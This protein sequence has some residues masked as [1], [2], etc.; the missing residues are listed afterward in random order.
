MDNKIKVIIDIDKTL[1]EN[2]VDHTRN[3]YI[4]SDVWIAVA[5]GRPL[6]S[7]CDCKKNLEEE[8]HVDCFE[9]SHHYRDKF[10]PNESEDNK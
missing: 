2:V 10:E 3:G 5:N 8:T 4:G 7:C 6:G 9:C 1:F